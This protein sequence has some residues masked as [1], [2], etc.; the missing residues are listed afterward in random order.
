[1]ADNPERQTYNSILLE[2]LSHYLDQHPEQR[3]TQ[4]LSNLGINEILTDDDK[5]VYVRDRPVLVDYYHEEPQVTLAR[6]VKAGRGDVK[7]FLREELKNEG[8]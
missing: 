3:F 2:I 8:G 5:P 4:A 7:R 1:M 6:V